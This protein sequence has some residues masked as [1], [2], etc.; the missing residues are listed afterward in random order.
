[1]SYLT[2]TG[3]ICG[4]TR[5]NCP[6]SQLFLTEYNYGKMLSPKSPDNGCSHW[7]L[8]G[9]FLLIHYLR[10][11]SPSELRFSAGQATTHPLL[12]RVRIHP[13]LTN[14]WARVEHKTRALKRPVTVKAGC[15]RLILKLFLMGHIKKGSFSLKG[16]TS[17]QRLTVR[18]DLRAD[19]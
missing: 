17:G 10:C 9:I 13:R 6:H 11:T 18:W 3:V 2:H 4:T 14:G 5:G 15:M 19:G 8:S 1:M 12:P 16:L 7:R